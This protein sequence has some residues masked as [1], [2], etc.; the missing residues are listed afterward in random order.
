[1]SSM[2]AQTAFKRTKTALKRIQAKAKKD[3]I[4]HKKR[5]ELNRQAKLK[6]AKS[7]ER[8]I[9]K[10]IEKLIKSHINEG[11]TTAQFIT[12]ILVN[13]ACDLA[14]SA[15][16]QRLRKD[17]YHVTYERFDS[18]FYTNGALTISWRFD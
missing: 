15:V 6:K 13:G 17:G 11:E 5:D 12:N 16:E 7:L 2:K 1:M 14:L 8:I 4:E 18:L 10:K 3:E 9:Y